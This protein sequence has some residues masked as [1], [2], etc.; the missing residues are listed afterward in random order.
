MQISYVTTSDHETLKKD[1]K[2]ISTPLSNFGLAEASL[3]IAHTDRSLKNATTNLN[4][5][6]KQ[7]DEYKNML[8]TYP[9]GSLLQSLI[10][11]LERRIE[12]ARRKEKEQ[13]GLTHDHIG[14]ITEFLAMSEQD[15]KGFKGMFNNIDKDKDGVINVQ[16]LVNFTRESL[17]MTPI[18]KDC[19]NFSLGVS[20]FIND[21]LSF[22]EFTRA[23][24]CFAMFSAHE[25]MKCIYCAIDKQSRGHIHQSEFYSFLTVLH[26]KKKIEM[27]SRSL[28]DATIPEFISFPSFEALATK[29]PK[30][31]FPMFRFQ[32][33]IRTMCLGKKWWYRKMRKFNYAKEKVL[34]D[35]ANG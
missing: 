9:N 35:Q 30:L 2:K 28:K 10:K 34:R 33:S 17:S 7:L 15:L 22:G 31:M 29:Y 21:K 18:I 19:L 24:G 6:Q 32:E 25:M 8:P 12:I 26:P 3:W 27:A 1:Y 16:E 13:R 20:D 4:I 11:E 14:Y 5:M 23:I